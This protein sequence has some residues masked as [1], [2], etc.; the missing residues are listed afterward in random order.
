ML[1]NS[2]L[3]DYLYRLWSD[4]ADG[5]QNDLDDPESQVRQQLSGLLSSLAEELETDEDIQSWVNEWLLAASVSVVDENR[6]AIS[7]LISDTVRSWDA[8]DTSARIELAI[9]RDLQFIRINGTLVGGLVGLAI[10][11]IKLM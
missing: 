6:Q 3:Q 5:L 2:D 1:E 7:S 8:G 9:G 4:L 10:H 11:A